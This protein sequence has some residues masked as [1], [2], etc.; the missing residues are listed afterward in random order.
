MQLLL[1]LPRSVDSCREVVEP[2]Q[3]GMRLGDV[4]LVNQRL[5]EYDTVRGKC[6]SVGVCV[7]DDLFSLFKRWDGEWG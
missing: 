1:L 5:C 7:F 3:W 6:C 2:N 4:T